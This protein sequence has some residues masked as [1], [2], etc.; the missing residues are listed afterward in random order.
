MPEI[1]SI[2]IDDPKRLRE[3]IKTIEVRVK[4]DFLKKIFS[5]FLLK[6]LIEEIIK[7]H[8]CENK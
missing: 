6:I 5:K 2:F 8:Q 1:N 7:F 4:T 3:P